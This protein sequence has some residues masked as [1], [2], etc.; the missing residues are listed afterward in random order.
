MELIDLEIKLD[1]L[2][3][4]VVAWVRGELDIYTAPRLREAMLEVL[5]G[6]SDP[7]V[8][9]LDVS[10]LEFVDSTGLGV[11]V[12]VLKRMRFVGGDLVIRAPSPSLRTLL[13]ITGLDKVFTVDA[14]TE[15]GAPIDV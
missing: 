6:R 9:T 15:L 3:D 1:V 5:T 11:M 14:L 2:G 10:G 7:F 13:G 8:I 12:A 4:D